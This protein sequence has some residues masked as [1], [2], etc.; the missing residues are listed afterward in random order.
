[1][2]V[3]IGSN[4]GVK[5]PA[6]WT[7]AA[8]GTREVTREVIKANKQR[9]NLRRR[10]LLRIISFDQSA[11]H[12]QRCCCHI[13]LAWSPA[14]RVPMGGAEEDG[15]LLHVAN[16]HRPRRK[17][18][19]QEAH[20]ARAESVHGCEVGLRRGRSSAPAA[21]LLRACA[22]REPSSPAA[23]DNLNGCA[24]AAAGSAGAAPVACQ[25]TSA[26]GRLPCGNA[27]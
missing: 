10:Q 6:D 3:C 26:A 8:V 27:R 17:S 21:Q 15:F 14:G 5:R 18:S 1:M 2:C 22:A 20:Y 13:A 25:S 23:T 16:K 11:S 9:N 7:A 12:L 4:H 24:S 19:P